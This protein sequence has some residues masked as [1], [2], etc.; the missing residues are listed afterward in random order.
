MR[1][2][3]VCTDPGVP[4]LGGRG[5]SVHMRE[6][7]R[8]LTSRG[9]SVAVAVAK[10][11]EGNPAPALRSIIRLPDDPLGQDDV[12]EEALQR[13]H[14][15]VVLER[16]A[17]SSGVA[18]RVS[19]RLGIPLLL[20][21]NAPIVLEAVRDGAVTDVERALE[22]EAWLFEAV[23]GVVAV[24]TSLADYVRTRAPD[25]RVTVVPNG[26]DP[27]LFRNAQPSVPTPPGSV[28]IGFS[29]SMY[30][31]QGAADLVRVF[32]A[33]AKRRDDVLLLLAGDGP[34]RQAIQ[35]RASRAPLARRVRLLG[36]LPHADVPGVLSSLDIAVA[37]FRP[38]E[39]FY[40]S[41]LT[42]LEYLAAGL[43]VVIPELGDLP[44]I[45]GDGALTYPPGDL[46]GLAEELEVLASDADL[47]SRVGEAARLR[48]ETFTWD[49]AAERL[50]LAAADCEGHVLG[51]ASR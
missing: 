21:V 4:F 38:S 22:R 5:A 43:P 15:D 51:S 10:L 48:S 33:I 6:L 50:E 32:A 41:P 36:E 23:G 8:A 13:F 45:C 37:P 31:S 28:T 29:G 20:E 1:I 3:Y 46:R 19:A 24:S 40:P 26:V 25:A 49:R 9:H 7:A 11:G 44:A 35:R 30:P 27:K 18:L 2:A 14:A 34:E 47:R 17:L 12:L 42:V 16:Y 39:D